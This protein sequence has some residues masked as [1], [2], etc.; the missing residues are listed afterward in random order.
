M[1]RAAATAIAESVTDDEL[2]ETFIMPPV[3]DTSVSARV[4][5]AVSA[6]AIADGVCRA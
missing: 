1:K 4:A 3:F 2:S 6:A 5:E